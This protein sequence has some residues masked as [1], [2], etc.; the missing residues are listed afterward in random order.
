MRPSSVQASS[1]DDGFTMSAQP[2]A[3][4][5]SVRSRRRPASISSCAWRPWFSC[6]AAIGSP[7]RMREIMMGRAV[8]PDPAIA[9]STHGA[10]VADAAVS[11]VPAT[12][13]FKIFD[14]FS[15]QKMRIPANSFSTAGPCV[16]LQSITSSYRID[17]C[18]NK[19]C[20]RLQDR[21]WL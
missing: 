17:V 21:D 16:S 5:T 8:P 2:P 18:V 11:A 13:D 3:S 6:V 1:N 4:A 15:S 19:I 7:P 12:R 14:I 20:N 10:M 9:P